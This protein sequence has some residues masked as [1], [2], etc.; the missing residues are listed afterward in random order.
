MTIYY[1]REDGNDSNPG[2]G[3][4]AALAWRTFTPGN[5]GGASEFEPGDSINVRAGSGY[6][7]LTPN[8]VNW[9]G[10]ILGLSV[11]GQSRLS[12]ITAINIST[13]ITNMVISDLR[14]T[15]FVTSLESESW[16]ITD[17]WFDG[18]NLTLSG[19]TQTFIENNFF[20]FRT[21][22]GGGQIIL[23][24]KEHGGYSFRH[25]TVIAHQ[26]SAVAPDIM[27]LNVLEIA[28]S[29]KEPG[30]PYIQMKNNV[31]HRLAGAH[32]RY[33]WNITIPGPTL[34]EVFY[35]IESNWYQYVK[36]DVPQLPMA[37]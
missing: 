6:G 37:R 15:S 36:T 11:F 3:D 18:A 22:G 2:T 12:I 13:N 10:S 28:G 34:W 19:L 30:F 5:S 8:T 9:V 25:N 4:S 26:D 23:K 20:D 1:L 21:V 35:I 16:R 7:I 31:F 33:I 24:Y 14:I 17:N 27:V 32:P 29:V